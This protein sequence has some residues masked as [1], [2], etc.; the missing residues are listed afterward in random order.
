MKR[1]PR[2]QEPTTPTKKNAVGKK[3]QAATKHLLWQE[4]EGGGVRGTKT[5]FG[6]K[7]TTDGANLPWNPITEKRSG[8]QFARED[9]GVRHRWRE[10]GPGKDR[11]GF[12]AGHEERTLEDRGSKWCQIPSRGK[13]PAPS[14]EKHWER[15]P[16]KPPTNNAGYETQ[17]KYLLVQRRRTFQ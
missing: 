13:F 17:K 15:V 11:K 5:R 6:T 8:L 7:T 16:N 12:R 10:E 14:G 9:R 4:E 1:G 3:A 2:V